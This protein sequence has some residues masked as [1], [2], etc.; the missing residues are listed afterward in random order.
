[1]NQVLL[2]AII[3]AVQTILLIIF[4]TFYAGAVKSKFDESL[5]S[6]K[7]G[8]S[9][10]VEKLKSDLALNVNS[11]VAKLQ[12]SLSKSNTAFQIHSAEYTKY[13]FD[14]VVKLYISLM[15]A[16]NVRINFNNKTTDILDENLEAEAD[17]A[18]AIIRKTL[19]QLSETSLFI[20]SQLEEN[21]NKFLTEEFLVM[22]VITNKEEWERYN[23]KFEQAELDENFDH[24]PIEF[25]NDELREQYEFDKEVA[26]V[27]MRALID[28]WNVSYEIYQQTLVKLKAEFKTELSGLEIKN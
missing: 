9:K 16:A 26:Y 22:S 13:K 25:S 20:S 1:M 17:N 21:I 18:R 3:T 15:E 5:E 28:K 23:D 4:K 19:D 12:A 11:E 6:V 27:N 7:S 24:K 8:F 10:D 14:K 2:V